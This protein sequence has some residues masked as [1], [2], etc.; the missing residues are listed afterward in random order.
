[1]WSG[2]FEEFFASPA[3]VFGQAERRRTAMAY[4]KA[5][6]APV[7]RRNGWQIGE[8]VGHATP[9]RVQWFL[10]RSTWL[11][12]NSATASVPSSPVIWDAPT[13]CWC[14]TRRRS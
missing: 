12:I 5:L 9:D 7:E 1:M 11:P 2:W 14:W 13:G 3:W 6:L 10:S 8:Y 4:L